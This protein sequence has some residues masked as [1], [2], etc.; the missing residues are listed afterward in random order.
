MFLVQCF[1]NM[2]YML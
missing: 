2:C 1:K